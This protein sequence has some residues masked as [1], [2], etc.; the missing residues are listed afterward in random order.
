MQDNQFIESVEEYILD[1][2]M[3]EQIS[4]ETVSQT[5]LMSRMQFYRKVKAITGKTPVE[6][7]RTIRLEKASELLETKKYTL[8]EIAY[9]VGFSSL[10]S[11]SKA[12]KKHYGKPPSEV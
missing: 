3:D 2:L 7:I 12:F 10:S 6:L 8:S 5:F 4:V 1:N 11:F 9:E